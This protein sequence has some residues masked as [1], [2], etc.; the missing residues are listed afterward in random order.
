MRGR[1]NLMIPRLQ[2][3]PLILT[4]RPNGR[5]A[6]SNMDLE[7]LEGKTTP[8]NQRCYLENIFENQPQIQLPEARAG[9]LGKQLGGNITHPVFP[10]KFHGPGE[11]KP[12]NTGLSFNAL[13]WSPSHATMERKAPA[14]FLAP[15]LTRNLTTRVHPHSL[16]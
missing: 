6:V 13:D 14:P 2:N 15:V 9:L 16:C 5:T 1:S 8:F 7:R 12:N 3:K 11:R 10:V 4:K